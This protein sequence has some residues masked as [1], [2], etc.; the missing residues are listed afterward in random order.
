MTTTPPPSAAAPA[1]TTSTTETA[2][3]PASMPTT[4]KKRSPKKAK[5][6]KAP[7]TPKHES[8][9]DTA[10]PSSPSSPTG[11]A[12]TRK[13]TPALK[14]TAIALRLRGMTVKKI[15]DSLGIN[16]KTAWNYLNRACKNKTDL[17]D[18]PATEGMSEDDKKEAARSL[19]IIGWSVKEIADALDM[20]YKTLWNYLDRQQKMADLPPMAHDPDV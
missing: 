12:A 4:P 16:Y 1:A 6:P 5:V 14:R 3:T 7:A 10:S 20:N 17:A 19:K 2:T 9:P 13:F 15:A 18:A 8:S 11:S